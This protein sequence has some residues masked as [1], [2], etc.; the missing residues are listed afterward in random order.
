MRPESGRLNLT[1]K[2]SNRENRNRILT[3]GDYPKQTLHLLGLKRMADRD[4]D[5][6]SMREYAF[7]AAIIVVAMVVT[8]FLV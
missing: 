5:P 1:K 2:T 3:V 7:V 6:H 4:Y 8:Y